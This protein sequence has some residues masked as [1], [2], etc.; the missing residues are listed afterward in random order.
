M[1]RRLSV[2][3]LVYRNGKVLSVKQYGYKTSSTNEYWC[4]PGGGLDDGE[5]LVNGLIREMVEEIGIK[6]DIGN[7]L[8]IQQFIHNEVDNLEFIYHIKNADDYLSIDLSK[9]THGQEEIDE[10]DFVDPKNVY[11]LP[12]FLSDSDI[13]R[14]IEAGVAINY[15]YLD[16]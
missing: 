13:G 8:Y 4:L 16:G 15:N 11:I 2:R 12:E 7:L 6:P 5:S 10:F 1:K 3:R 14:D 9:T